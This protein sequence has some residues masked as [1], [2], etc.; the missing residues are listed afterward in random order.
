LK[1]VWVAVQA[2]GAELICFI[3]ETEFTS[4]CGLIHFDSSNTNLWPVGVY[5]VDLSMND[6]LA[7]PLGL[8][9]Q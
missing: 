2:E 5:T 4:K 7:N 9:I 8:T 1:A 3:Q 6:T